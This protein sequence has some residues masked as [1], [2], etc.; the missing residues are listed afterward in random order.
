MKLFTT[1]AFFQKVNPA[2]TWRMPTEDRKIYLTF[3]DGPTEEITYWILDSL[4]Q[5]NALATFFCVGENISQ[6][7]A[8]MQAMKEAGHTV[9]N[10]TYNHLNGFKTPVNEYI[11]N[12]E[13]CAPLVNN[14]L[15]RP[16]YGKITQKQSGILRQKGYSI[17][18]WSLL[19]YDYLENLDKEKAFNKIKRYA[20][21]GSIIVFHDNIKAEK[22]MKYLLPKTLEFL[23]ENGFQFAAL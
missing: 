20:E 5:F 18:M 13:K 2:R 9:G 22:N 6:Y 19:T 15:F 12:T 8:Q 17:I 11:E 4:K 14:L 1:P 16:P 3:D 21:A 7:T 10:H 23:S